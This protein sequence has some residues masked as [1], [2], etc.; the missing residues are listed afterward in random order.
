MRLK[1]RTWRPG[2]N[3]TATKREVT[4]NG[5]LSTANS[6][7]KREIL[8]VSTFNGFI[9]LITLNEDLSET[10][11]GPA[12]KFILNYSW[13]HPT[14]TGIARHA[15]HSERCAQSQNQSPMTNPL[16]VANPLPTPSGTSVPCPQLYFKVINIGQRPT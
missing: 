13:P 16:A 7:N 5:N 10:W 9:L 1:S 6:K 3:T 2:K 11:D 15:S 12:S 8:H 14:P 4:Q